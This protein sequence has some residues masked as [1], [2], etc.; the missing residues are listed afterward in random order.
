MI[1]MTLK[2]IIVG[3]LLVLAVVSVILVYTERPILY[4][5]VQQFPNTSNPIQTELFF[6]GTSRVNESM[7]VTM[8][9]RALQAASNVTVAMNLSEGLV[10]TD[11]NLTWKKTRPLR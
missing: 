7:I 5:V 1:K 9:I 11:G 10:L 2:Y 3:I 4:S 6:S 8:R